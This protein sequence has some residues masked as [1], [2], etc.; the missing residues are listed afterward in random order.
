MN[1]EIILKGKYC[2]QVSACHGV[3]CSNNGSCIEGKNDYRCNCTSNFYNK[4]CDVQHDS[5]LSNPCHF[6]TCVS[7]EDGYM[8]DECPNKKYYGI[9]SN[10]NNDK[11]GKLLFLYGYFFFRI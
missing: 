5:C 11:C 10:D 9:I 1:N 7:T 8:C 6:G 3:T 2:E 4:T